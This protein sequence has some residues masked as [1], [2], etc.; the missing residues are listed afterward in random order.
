MQYKSDTQQKNIAWYLPRPKKDHYKGSMPLYC[1]EWLIALAKELLQ[2]QEIKLL[3]LFCGM[4]RY[5]FRV[6]IK[7]EVNPDVCCDAHSLTRYVTDTFDVILAD[8]PYSN[9][10]AK[11]LYNTS[12]LH[13]KTWTHECEQLLKKDGILIIYHKY[14]MPN[15]NPQAFKVIKRVFIGNRV[16]HTPRV[17]IFF[18]KII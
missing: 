16:Y 6:D 18:Q 2:Q 10:E 8:P 15:P 9:A 14:I 17:A 3:N 1:E 13:Y 4:N 7:P 12:A 5:G 11:Q